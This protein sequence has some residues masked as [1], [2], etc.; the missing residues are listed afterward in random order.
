M[1]AHPSSRS[2]SSLARNLISIVQVAAFL[3]DAKGDVLFY[4]EAAGDI[5]GRRFEETGRLTREQW[6]A[7]GPSTR[8]AI[9]NWT[10][11]FR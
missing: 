9:R 11:R 5:V 7:I 3:T 6:N 4:N 8:R 2:S 1:P 10:S